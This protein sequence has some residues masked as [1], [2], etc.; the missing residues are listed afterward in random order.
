MVKLKSN[1]KFDQSLPG[2][3]KFMKQSDDKNPVAEIIQLSSS[4]QEDGL[5][6]QKTILF[7]F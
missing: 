5:N 1:L 6:P 7:K 4:D 3:I 2:L